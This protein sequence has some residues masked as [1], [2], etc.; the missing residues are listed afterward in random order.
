LGSGCRRAFI[1]GYFGEEYDPPCGNCDNDDAG[2]EVVEGGDF[3]VGER[4]AHGEWGE[5]TVGQV[6][7]G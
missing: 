4:V 3:E 7:D 1:L 2:H 6:E 5:G